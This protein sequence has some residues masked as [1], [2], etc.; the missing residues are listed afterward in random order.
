[1]MDLEKELTYG[2]YSKKHFLSFILYIVSC[3]AVD[4]FVISLI[5]INEIEGLISLLALIVLLLQIVVVIAWIPFP[6]Y[7]IER[8]FNKN[9]DYNELR[10]SF[11]SIISNNINRETKNYVRLVLL[12]YSIIFDMPYATKL[13][14]DVYLPRKTTE[15]LNVAY[16]Q[17]MFEFYITNGSHTKAKGILDAM[18]QYKIPKNIFNRYSL[19][20][21][22]YIENEIYEKELIAF[23]PVS[24]D[25]L[26]RIVSQFGLALYSK[27]IQNKEKF[28]L[29]KKHINKACQ[30][31]PYFRQ[32]TK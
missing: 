6:V 12:R 17:A 13:L 16:Y 27:T 22:V 21:S 26:E 7:N 19:L 11:E 9:R 18:A 20:Y 32:L 1:M 28:E 8:R 3:V 14:K 4:A 5:I 30:N 10:S 2:F 24:K 31:N 23:N 25:F 29:Y 15:T